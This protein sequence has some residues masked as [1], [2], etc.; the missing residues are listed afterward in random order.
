[1]EGVWGVEGGVE[2]G[3]G[4]FKDS[5]NIG[6]VKGL[7]PGTGAVQ[8]VRIAVRLSVHTAVCGATLTQRM[9]KGGVY[10]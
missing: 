4:W 5:G 1:V 10:D 8:S 9:T 2:G 6:V 3:V 7:A